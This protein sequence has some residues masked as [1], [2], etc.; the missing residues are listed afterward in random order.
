[1]HY[2]ENPFNILRLSM[3][4]NRDTIVQKADDMCF[5]EP[6]N[7]EAIEQAKGVL[8][9]PQRRI[10]AEL[11]W[12]PEVSTD[13]FD[14]ICL[15]EDDILGLNSLAAMNF[16]LFAMEMD[17]PHDL[18]DSILKVD[19]L[20][21]TISIDELWKLLNKE[22]KRAG[23]PM[24]QE[25]AMLKAPWQER[26][27]EIKH[28]IQSCIEKLS[29]DVYIQISG[30][31]AEQAAA[32]G[33][34]GS[35]LQD[36]IDDYKLAQL[37]ANVQLQD[38]FKNEAQHFQQ[39][40]ANLTTQKAKITQAA[41]LLK[42][43][44]LYA[45][46]M[47]TGDLYTAGV[48]KYSAVVYNNSDEASAES[49]EELLRYIR[50]AFAYSNDVKEVLDKPLARIEQYKAAARAKEEAEARA[51]AEAEAERARAEAKAKAE[52]EAIAKAAA[53]A[54]ARE[55][56]QAQSYNPPARSSSSSYSSSSESSSSNDD[57]CL[58]CFGCLGLLVI[59][60]AGGA[61]AGPPGVILAIVLLVWICSM[62]G[63]E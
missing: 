59:A 17:S 42:P 2:K 47:G 6:E 28:I 26:R 57:G 34:F 20:Y 32:R 38:Y 22:R 39:G 60:G 30:M 12:L 16:R 7:E 11:S 31:I 63:D 52:A 18:A 8:L 44:N 62:F 25:A 50:S 37:Q 48:L 4:A 40:R 61:F 23:F 10:K 29:N 46:T 3:E 36:Y 35:I 9:N 15:T 58:S 43:L 55:A 53:A 54:R 5:D 19:E 56:A 24:I 27:G 14:K 45:Q 21:A 33:K 41:N 49:T 13:I 51:K 1:M